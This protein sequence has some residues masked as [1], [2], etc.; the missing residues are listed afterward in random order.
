M[1]VTAII[2]HICPLDLDEEKE[3]EHEMEEQSKGQ[4]GTSAP[5]EQQSFECAVDHFGEPLESPCL[6]GDFTG[7]TRSRSRKIHP[8]ARI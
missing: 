7:S 1:F 3:L 2:S 5:H 8:E 6:A 4:F